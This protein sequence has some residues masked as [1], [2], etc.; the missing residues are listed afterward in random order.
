M[1]AFDISLRLKDMEAYVEGVLSD[2]A[3][4]MPD[5]KI[6][7]FGHLGDGN[8]HFI[9]G[10]VNDRQQLENIVYGR[11]KTYGGSV[12]AEH[13]IGLEKKDFLSFSR[14]DAEIKMMKTIKQALDPKGLLNRNKIFS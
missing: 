13:G 6:V 5:T 7:S 12:S 4:N 9:A 1:M 2:V 8:I 11:V 14:S 10:P 3:S